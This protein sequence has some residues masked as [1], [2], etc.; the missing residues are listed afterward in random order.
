MRQARSWDPS[1][2]RP[3]QAL[4][5]AHDQVASVRHLKGMGGL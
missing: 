3:R 4:L 1:P 5:T 2:P